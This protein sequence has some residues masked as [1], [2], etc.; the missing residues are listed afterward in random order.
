[1]PQLS[2]LYS[3]VCSKLHT[4]HSNWS[5]FLFSQKLNLQTFSKFEALLEPFFCWLTSF[6]LLESKLRLTLLFPKHMVQ[7][8]KKQCLKN[9]MNILTYQNYYIL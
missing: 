1:M 9:Y 5:L 7:I 4:V 8:I 3:T 2:T 6:F